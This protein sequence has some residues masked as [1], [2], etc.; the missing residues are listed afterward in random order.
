[1][2]YRNNLAYQRIGCCRRRLNWLREIGSPS[3]QRFQ[4]TFF[5]IKDKQLFCQNR[6][7]VQHVDQKTERAYVITQ[8][9]KSTS[10]SRPHFVDFGDQ[11]LLDAVAHTR[12]GMRRLVK[13]QQRKNAAHLR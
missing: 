1:M 3:H 12:Y 4:F 9:I 5:F 8:L 11:H 13:S 10:G 7:I 2:H 6:L